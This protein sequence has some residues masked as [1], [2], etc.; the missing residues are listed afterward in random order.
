MIQCCKLGRLLRLLR[1]FLRSIREPGC[2][3][4]KKPQIRTPQKGVKETNNLQ[5]DKKVMNN[6][7]NL[8][9]SALT[10]DTLALVNVPVAITMHL[11][12]LVLT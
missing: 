6:R 4:V 9:M 8:Q 11:W 7:E 3:F 1:L 10:I 2:L 12:T 5:D